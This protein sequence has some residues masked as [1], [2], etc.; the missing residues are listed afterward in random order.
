MNARLFHGIN[1]NDVKSIDADSFRFHGTMKALFYRLL[2]L[3]NP[4]P[5]EWLDDIDGNI[6]VLRDIYREYEQHEKQAWR[7]D[8]LTR[9]IPFSL[10][11]ANYD[12][13]YEEVIQ[14][15][16]WRIIQERERFV[17]E[18]ENKDPRYWFQDG[19]GRIALSKENKLIAQEYMNGNK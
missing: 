16:L 7:K 3:I 12:E 13:N 17:F 11:L 2:K 14:W 6:G 19:R 5:K 9:V 18:P 4:P 10:C 8:T 1:G 15:F